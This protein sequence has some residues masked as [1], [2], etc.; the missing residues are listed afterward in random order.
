MSVVAQNVTLRV[1]G[2]DGSKLTKAHCHY[3]Q[4]LDADGAVSLQL[5]GETCGGIQII[6][7]HSMPYHIFSLSS[8]GSTTHAHSGM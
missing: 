6:S 4:D 7:N 3:K 1:E 2:I 8:R 5:G